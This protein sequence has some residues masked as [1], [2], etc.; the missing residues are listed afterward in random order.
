MLTTDPEDWSQFSKENETKNGG[1]RLSTLSSWGKNVFGLIFLRKIVTDPKAEV[2]TNGS[3]HSYPFEFS[4]DYNVVELIW[5]CLYLFYFLPG[6]MY[7]I[8]KEKSLI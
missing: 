2:N 4:I 3:Y 6:I 8:L 1:G 7:Y 5:K